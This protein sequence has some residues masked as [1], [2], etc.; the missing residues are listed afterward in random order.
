MEQLEKKL[1]VVKA[2]KVAKAAQKIKDHGK[3]V[4]GVMAEFK[5]FLK[6]YKILGI[7]AGLV[8]GSAVTTLTGA[9]VV[10]LVTPAL[11][12]LIPSESIKSLVFPVGAVTFQVGAVVSALINFIVVALLFFLFVKFFMKQEKVTKESVSK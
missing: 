9:I 4:G 8:I 2:V 10:G 5:D 12:L 6:E 1:A 7:A 3:K 11:Q